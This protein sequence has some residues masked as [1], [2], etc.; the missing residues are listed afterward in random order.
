MTEKYM[1]DWG[2]MTPIS[3]FMVPYL[4]LVGAHLVSFN[5]FFN[6]FTPILGEMIQFDEHVVQL[7][8]FFT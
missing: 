7:G 2:E 6:I 8:W 4:Q 1:G 3:G 5:V